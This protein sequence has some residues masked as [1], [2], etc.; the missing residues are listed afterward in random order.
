MTTGSQHRKSK[1]NRNATSPSILMKFKNTMQTDD[2]LSVAYEEAAPQLPNV[3]D[4]LHDLMLILDARIQWPKSSPLDQATRSM[5]Q[6][7]FLELYD[8]AERSGESPANWTVSNLVVDQARQIHAQ[9]MDRGAWETVIDPSLVE[10]SLPRGS[11]EIHKYGA[12]LNQ[13]IREHLCTDLQ[14]ACIVWSRETAGQTARFAT[15]TGKVLWCLTPNAFFEDRRVGAGS[16]SVQKLFKRLADAGALIQDQGR[17]SKARWLPSPSGCTGGLARK[18][19]PW[20]EPACKIL[21]QD[22]EL[23]MQEFQ[24]EDQA[25]PLL[26]LGHRL[27][28]VSE[29]FGGRERQ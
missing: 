29:A 12:A 15:P 10:L 7:R 3:C 5:V 21:G 26:V 20:F 19:G 17:G 24:V 11:G 1:R 28:V 8:V 16:K 18:R 9:L 25:L 14:T 23:F 27:G 22:V 6:L 2:L 13:T 4:K